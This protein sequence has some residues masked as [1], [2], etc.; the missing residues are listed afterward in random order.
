[1]LDGKVGIV[2]GA[3]Q[4]LG[5]AI[6][7]WSVGEGR[8]RASCIEICSR[9]GALDKGLMEMIRRWA[10]FRI[11]SLV[12]VV[13]WGVLVVVGGCGSDDD[14][15][16]PADFIEVAGVAGDVLLPDLP[17]GRPADLSLLDAEERAVVEAADGRA[18]GIRKTRVA[19]W[20]DQPGVE[21]SVSQIRHGFTFGFPI[22]L[23]SRPWRLGVVHRANGR[24]LLP[25]GA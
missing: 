24:E 18:A 15:G 19:M 4:G 16:R 2:T 22:E 12:G 25:G 23:V 9:C 10:R 7:V 6:S 5:E 17:K 1:M 3:P 20:I 21:V 11:C 14:A 13:A 8:R